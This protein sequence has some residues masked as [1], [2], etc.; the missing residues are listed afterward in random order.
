MAG[1][2]FVR[3]RR[4]HHAS[5][6]EHRAF[7]ACSLLPGDVVLTQ[8]IA[9]R[10]NPVYEYQRRFADFPPASHVFTHVAIAIGN[11]KLM[12]SVPEVGLDASRSGGV[13]EIHGGELFDEQHNFVAIR[14]PAV[15]P[16]QHAKLVETARSHIGK[17]YD[18]MS[19]ARCFLDTGG[20][21]RSLR[22]APRMQGKPRIAKSKLKAASES[23]D[24]TARS[25][26]CSDF[27]WAVFDEVLGE[28][29]PCNYPGGIRASIYLPCA[30]FACP[31]F[32]DVSLDLL[33]P[34]LLP[35]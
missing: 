9:P 3:T 1:G 32:V 13:Y 11:S 12:H 21:V 24:Q 20:L 31:N 8:R 7:A 17:P 33:Q 4:M 29:N 35:T 28:A 15:Q 10:P 22:G 30:F 14:S 16:T 23:M 25:F 27:V 5:T 19:I 34:N 6:A 18:Y 26:V 2:H